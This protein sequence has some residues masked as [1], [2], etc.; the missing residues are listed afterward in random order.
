MNREDLFINF[1]PD[2]YQPKPE[3]RSFPLVA[4]TVL[5]LVGLG[6]YLNWRTLDSEREL[7]AS[8]I[9]NKTEQLNIKQKQAMEFIPVQAKARVV[10]LYLGQLMV[11]RSANPPWYDVYNRVEEILP[12]GVWIQNLRFV[13][14]RKGWPGVSM[15]VVAAGGSYSPLYNLHVNLLRNKEYFSNVRTTGFTISK[16]QDQDVM[17][18]TF[19]FQLVKTF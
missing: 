3:W 13:R 9:K 10:Y 7:L 14:P 2:E 12:E 4:L 18:S 17:T 19:T 5:I 15:T 8:D 16:L 6:V 1:L 11:L